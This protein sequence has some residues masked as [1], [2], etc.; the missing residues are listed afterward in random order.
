[1]ITEEIKS[2]ISHPRF[3]I[4]LEEAN[5]NTNAAYQLYLINI[6]LSE[7]LYPAL[8]LLEISL[9]NAIHQKLK[10]YFNDDFWFKNQLPGEFQTAIQRAERKIQ[11]QKKTVTADGIIAELNFG[12]WNRLFNRYHAKLLWKP[13]RT[14]F[15]H[16]PKQEKQRKN[17]DESLHRIR[18][19]R[20]RVYHYEPIFRDFNYLASVY[21]EI[22]LL[23]FWLHQLLP[24]V[25]NKV[26]RFEYILMKVKTH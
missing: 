11:F 24:I 8:S 14:I 13:L 3:N 4:Y 7:A 2:F 20:N 23:L 5:Y 15:V 18:N 10:E 25:L 19:I 1:M 16:L 6:E 12:F 17:I 22:R 26:D 21:Q 9:R